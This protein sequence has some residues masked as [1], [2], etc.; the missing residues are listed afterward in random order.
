MEE[1]VNERIIEKI[2]KSEYDDSV[3]EF[4]LESIREEF[5]HYG[6]HWK[7]TDVYDKNIKRYSKDYKITKEKVSENRQ[8]YPKKL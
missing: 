1:D 2:E 4:L 7:Y 5:L 6:R 3:K 8:D